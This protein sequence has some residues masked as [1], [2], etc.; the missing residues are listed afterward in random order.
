[1]DVEPVLTVPM[2]NLST[3][4]VFADIDVIV[5]PIICELVWLIVLPDPPT[6]LEKVLLLN[7]V[8]SY[9]V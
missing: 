2:F 6:I 4:V 7:G 8:V 9:G 3:C 1:M 5:V